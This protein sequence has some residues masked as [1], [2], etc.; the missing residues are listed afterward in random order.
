MSGQ[1]TTH[2]PLPT[3][4]CTGPYSTIAPPSI[5][6]HRTSLLEENVTPSFSFLLLDDAFAV[7]IS[8]LPYRYDGNV[9]LVAE[10]YIYPAHPRFCAASFFFF[11]VFFFLFLCI[12]LLQY[13]SASSASSS[14]PDPRPTLTFI[15][16][17]FSFPVP[18][19]VSASLAFALLL[20]VF[21]ISPRRH[22]LHP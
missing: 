13:R 7:F 8:Q 12:L 10:G 5:C 11:F 4:N 22:I 21:P 1:P 14:F 18:I 15:Q 9:R 19:E 2:F 17:P 16:S 20:A 3:S 6:Q